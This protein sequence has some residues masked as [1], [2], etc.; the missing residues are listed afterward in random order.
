[1]EI[2]SDSFNAEWRVVERLGG[3]ETRRDEPQKPES[4]MV[5]ITT[6]QYTLHYLVTLRRGVHSSGLVANLQV[7]QTSLSNEHCKPVLIVDFP[8]SGMS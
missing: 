1:M 5:F 3:T 7:S 4:A 8:Q 6:T 2:E